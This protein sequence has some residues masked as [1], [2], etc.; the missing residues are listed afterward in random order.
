MRT[1]CQHLGFLLP[2]QSLS[3][4]RKPKRR[5]RGSHLAW[6]NLHG[7]GQLR[8]LRGE[9][10]ASYD[11]FFKASWKLQRAWPTPRVHEEARESSS[12]TVSAEL[13]APR[14]TV[15][16]K[17][18]TISAT[19]TK[20]VGSVASSSSSATDRPS[21]LKMYS[22]NLSRYTFTPGSAYYDRVEDCLVTTEA[23]ETV[24]AAIDA[25]NGGYMSHQRSK[26]AEG[27]YDETK[28]ECSDGWILYATGP[29]E[30]V[31]C[32]FERLNTAVQEPR[33]GFLRRFRTLQIPHKIHAYRF[34]FPTLMVATEDFH[35]LVYDVRKK[36]IAGNILLSKV[37]VSPQSTL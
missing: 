31:I 3:S 19:A 37:P 35:C 14:S 7:R 6:S 16:A 25:R 13:A 36:D 12:T 30:I 33:R 34:H 8:G 20:A 4:L 9:D 11:L 17:R 27:Y 29:K 32:R 18:D 26:R 22:T 1:L 24:V 5:L 10:L 28:L 2:G 23:Y 15:V 21:L